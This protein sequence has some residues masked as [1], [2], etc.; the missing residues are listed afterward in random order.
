MFPL[1]TIQ[2]NAET[3]FN[4]QVCSKVCLILLATLREAEEKSTWLKVLLLLSFAI[5]TIS[6]RIRFYLYSEPVSQTTSEGDLIDFQPVWA[7]SRH[8]QPPPPARSHRSMSS[9]KQTERHTQKP[10]ITLRHIIYCG[11]LATKRRHTHTQ[12]NGS[13]VS[14]C[15]SNG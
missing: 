9:T 4:T 14:S 8:L 13:F 11:C 2:D 15:V 10:L 5:G 6:P 1:W 3:D 7:Q 12:H